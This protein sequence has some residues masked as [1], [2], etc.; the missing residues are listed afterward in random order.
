MPG[1][2]TDGDRAPDAAIDAKLR[3]HE[4]LANPWYTLLVF[5]RDA[6]STA[7]IQSL[8]AE[9]AGRYGERVRVRTIAAPALASSAV[10]GVVAADGEAAFSIYGASDGDALCLVRP[11]GYVALRRRF[12]ERDQLAATLAAVLV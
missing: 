5:Q 4:L 3:V 12:A 6:R 1:G 8:A 9:L 2:L 7:A 11:D 10:S